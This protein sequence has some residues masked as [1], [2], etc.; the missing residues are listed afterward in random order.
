MIWENFCDTFTWNF[1][2]YDL[3]PR[4]QLENEACFQFNQDLPDEEWFYQDLIGQSTVYWLSI[5]ARY[6]EGVT[7]QYPWGWKTR[8]H[9]F[10]D[11][12][13]RIIAPEGWV[14]VIG[15]QWPGG[16]PIEFPDGT[17]WDLAFEL[18]T[19]EELD[20][21]DAPDPSYPTLLGSNGARHGIVPGMF[22]GAGVDPE[23]DGQPDASATGDDLLDGND[24][25][26]GVAFTS[27]L[28]QG[29]QGYVTVTASVA[30]HLNAWI[31]FNADSDWQD[32]GEKIFN[33]Y[34]LAAGSTPL[35]FQI[36]ATAGTG[37]TFA[38]F[39]FSSTRCLGD[40][41]PASD[42]EVE[43]Y[44]VVIEPVEEAFDF[45]DA[46]DPTYPTL[47][48][49]IGA[50]HII[51]PGVFLGNGVDPEADG[52]P[53]IPATGDDADG[54]DDEDGVAFVTLLLPGAQATVNVI[55]STPGYLNAWIDFNQNGNWSDAGEQIFFDTQHFGGL[56][57]L[58]FPVPATASGST[59]ARFRFTTAP[60]GVPNMF[61]GLLPDGEVED[62]LV[63]IGE[64][65]PGVD[66]GDAP[67]PTYPTLLA[68]NGARHTIVTG[69][70]LGLSI[71][72][73]SDGQPT[74]NAMGD[75]ILDGNDDEDGITFT[76]PIIPGYSAS[77]NI[78]TT[79]AGLLSA[80]IDFNGDGDWADTGE[81]ILQDLSVPLGYSNT[82]FTVPS[83]AKSGTTYARFR[84]STQQG[85]SYNGPAP[86][87]EVEDYTV[88]IATQ[89]DF[90]DAPDPKYP[91]L[92]ASNGAGHVNDGLTYLGTGPDS[93]LDGQ[94]NPNALGDDQT[95]YADEDGVVFTSFLIPGKQAAITVTTSGTGVLNAWLDFNADGDWADAGEQIFLD[96]SLSAVNNLTFPV[97]AN[98]TLGQTFA[99]FRFSNQTGLSYTGPA[100]DGEVEDYLVTIVAPEINLK[101]GS[102]TILSGGSY[103]FG[104][105]A[106]GGGKTVTF[107]IQNLGTAN[108]NLTGSPNKVAIS[109]TNAADFSVS[110]AQPFS[111]VAPGS[112]V[113]FN[114]KFTPG[115]TGT[116]TALM[117]IAN[118]DSNEN[119]Y[120]VTVTG[121]GQA[122]GSNS[123]LLWTR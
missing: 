54:N 83:G 78:T 20:F 81:K 32:A 39:R 46:P 86:N 64:E 87:E 27:P 15:S 37:A 65:E 97:P 119:P 34:A 90:G 11:D 53:N 26:D 9:F 71:D 25:E 58:N 50:Q 96:R 17:S 1:A 77:I 92:L 70:M 22:L 16:E 95:G 75:D 36:P 79:S 74:L 108:L 116:R 29:S 72:G 13:V 68:S 3:D 52:Q 66:F 73:E 115:A 102:A 38:R 23:L 49:S 105:V 24:D 101:Q 41:G 99:R 48:A 82:T 40:D 85:L 88:V 6:P 18:T 45:G 62:Y 4:D 21:G 31:D 51:V 76:S 56:N 55:A 19:L 93:E 35:N 61:T 89:P 28:F 12:A 2:G 67:D 112:S 109:G 57:P 121:T 98:A 69:M 122:Q 8:P 30:G 33:C 104:N 47:L 84:F 123:Y 44:R 42:G 118:N 113:I 59:Y 63:W 7:P 14:P 106:V 100:F 103:G 60:V 5:A 110:S 107:T 91:T 43:D 80:W 94:P 10:N 117:T 111:P 114:L 120:T